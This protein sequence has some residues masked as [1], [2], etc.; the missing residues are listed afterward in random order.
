MCEI[1]V[2]TDLPVAVSGGAVLRVTAR[3]GRDDRV[4]WQC[5]GCNVLYALAVRHYTARTLQELA[6]EYAHNSMLQN[7]YN[8]KSRTTTQQQLNRM[9][10]TPEDKPAM[11]IM[12]QRVSESS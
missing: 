7:T 3:R 9:I 4:P 1:A 8:C 5:H 11:I 10:L 2:S 12:N 6:T